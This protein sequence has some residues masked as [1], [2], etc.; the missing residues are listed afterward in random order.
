MSVF[1]T[2]SLYLDFRAVFANVSAQQSNPV[3][4]KTGVA[5][6]SD[7]RDRTP[8]KIFSG[9]ILRNVISG[10]AHRNCGSCSIV[11][12]FLFIFC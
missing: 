8:H 3:D 9:V 5:G 10:I 2:C 1:I 7:E 12:F 11:Q 4:V 6:R